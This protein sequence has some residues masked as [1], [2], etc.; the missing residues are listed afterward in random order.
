M[1]FALM[2]ANQDWVDI[3]P[4]KR[5][6]HGTYRAKPHTDSEVTSDGGSLSSNKRTSVHEP[7]P[8]GSVQELLVFDGFMNRTVYN[9]A[10]KYIAKNYFTQ[11]NYYR[12]PTLLPNGTTAQCCFFSFYQPEVIAMADKA[13]GTLAMG[14]FRAAA[15]SVGECLHL[16]HQG[17]ERD[18]LVAERGVSSV[19][20][21]GWMKTTRARLVS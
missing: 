10:F 3:H 5:G 20:D 18:S 19:F 6:W 9:S 12:V 17:S 21:Y 16:N 4:A 8:T 1:K 13:Q 15:E 7:Q 11:P 2:W 14:D